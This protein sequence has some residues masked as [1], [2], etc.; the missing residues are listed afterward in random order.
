MHVPSPSIGVQIEEGVQR[1]KGHIL[2]LFLLFV[3]LPSLNPLLGPSICLEPLDLSWSLDLSFSRL[4]L[5]LSSMSFVGLSVF[6][7]VMFCLAMHSLNPPPLIFVLS[8]KIIPCPVKQTT[9]CRIYNHGEM[10]TY[11]CNS[12]RLTFTFAQSVWA[13]RK[14]SCLSCILHRCLCLSLWCLVSTCLCVC[15][16]VLMSLSASFCPTFVLSFL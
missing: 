15:V 4:V 8:R 2:Y 16:S 7:F 14:S 1:R 11:I 5:S 9:L 3:P 12:T 10:G 13:V 6:S